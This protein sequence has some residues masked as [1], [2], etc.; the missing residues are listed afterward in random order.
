[1]TRCISELR[2]TLG[3]D[4]KEPHVIQTIPKKG[5]RLMP[6]VDQPRKPNRRKVSAYAV[7]AAAALIASLVVYGLHW[8]GK[9]GRSKT[10]GRGREITQRQLTS[11]PSERSLIW[12][13]ISPDGKYLAYTDANGLY[14][15]L[16]DTGE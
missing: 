13:A 8:R 12:A 3:D 15:R 6:A 16:L 11:N 14:L 4:A 2:R 5:Y 10:L 7:V 9:T 1:L